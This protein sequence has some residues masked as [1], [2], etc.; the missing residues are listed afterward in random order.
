M[1]STS[2]E[3]WQSLAALRLVIIGGERAAVERLRTWHKIAGAGIRLANEYGPTEATVCSTVWELTDEARTGS[4]R[5]V[6]IGRPLN[7]VQTYI[8][9]TRL[10]PVPPGVTGHLHI[11]GVNLARG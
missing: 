1:A 10:R 2:A 7:N 4:L 5:E 3:D 6:P 11:A 8:L 9:D